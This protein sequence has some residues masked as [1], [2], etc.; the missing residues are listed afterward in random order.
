[1]AIANTSVVKLVKRFEMKVERFIVLGF[2]ELLL[3]GVKEN[4]NVTA[5][6]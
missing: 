3:V 5:Q 2:G 1:M 4:Q 6:R